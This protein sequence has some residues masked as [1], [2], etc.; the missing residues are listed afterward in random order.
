M[1]EMQDGLYRDSSGNIIRVKNGM[2][3]R[4]RYNSTTKP[5][6][7]DKYKEIDERIYLLSS[8]NSVVNAP[9]MPPYNNSIGGNKRRKRRT[10]RRRKKRQE[11]RK[12]RK[13]IRKTRRR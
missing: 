1:S 6:D 7:F 10:L 13:R 12:S 5:D 4:A 9:K 3:Y 11:T 8:G 2:Y